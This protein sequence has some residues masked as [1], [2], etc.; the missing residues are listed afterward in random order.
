MQNKP[1]K[2]L[3]VCEFI[4]GGGLCAAPLSESLTKE[5]IMMRDALL[6][7]LSDLS[8]YSIISMHDARLKPSLLLDESHAVQGDC[9]SFE[10]HFKKLLKKVDYLWLIAPETDGILLR[11]CKLCYAEE[12]KR[13]SVML[14]GC[15]YDAVLIGTSKSL[16]CRTCEDEKIH[17]LPVYAGDK[18]LNDAYFESVLQINSH[19]KQWVA[20]PEDGAGCEGIRLFEN[21]S[22]LRDWL[23]AENLS[24]NYFAQAFQ[25][26]FA[27][28]FCMLCAEGKAW[29]LSS[30]MQHV[31]Q[32]K[33]RFQLSGVILNGAPQ[34]WQR[35]ETIARKLAKAMP[36]ALG[37]V[38]V[39]VMIDQ[40]Q[41]QIKVIDINPRLT[42]SYVGLREAIGMNSAQLILDCVLNDNFKMPAIQKQTV[43]VKI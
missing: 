30:N 13:G 41:D 33:D 17:T 24:F 15:G 11:F 14:I 23:V 8:E 12:E 21:L 35:F 39:D 1:K 27:A 22:D 10:T 38:G 7:D 3:L 4:T 26:G 25:I 19:V 34:Y 6:R 31:V 16:T 43:E 32:V 2:K 28:S 40:E 42:T 5:G 18:L 29:L 36:D 20:K 37:Y 9:K